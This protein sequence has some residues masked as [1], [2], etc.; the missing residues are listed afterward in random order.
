VSWANEYTGTSS[1]SSAAAVAASAT[2]TVAAAANYAVASSSSSAASSSAAASSASSAS[3]SEASSGTISS[4]SGGWS[5]SAYYDSA[6]GTSS[7]LVFLNHYGGSGSGV[8]DYTYGNSLSYSNA[9]GTGA[10]SSATTLSSTTIG[11]DV[12][13]VIMTDNECNGDC[14]YVRNGTV[15][16]HGFDGASKAFFFEFQMPSI[17]GSTASEYDPVNMPA[18]W[19]LNAQIPRTLQYGNASCSCWTSGCGEFDIFEVLAAG[20]SRMKSTLHGNVAGGDSDYFARP[21]SATMKAA[22]VLYNNNIHIQVLDD[23]ATF[24]ES[25]A[26]STLSDIISSTSTQTNTVSLFAL[27]S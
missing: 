13:I 17:G 14:G 27:S 9:D 25:L 3:A 23:S 22:L 20:D 12:E 19:A 5:R 15:A 7:G 11:S 26:A 2:T 6:S 21:E 10:A 16:Y 1:T 4:T 18:I 8:F 24:D